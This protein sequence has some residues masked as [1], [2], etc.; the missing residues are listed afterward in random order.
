MRKNTQREELRSSEQWKQGNTR[1]RS[2]R[3]PA[4]EQVFLC[5][6]ILSSFPVDVPL[7]LQFRLAFSQY[8]WHCSVISP[9]DINNLFLIEPFILAWKNAF[10]LTLEVKRLV[11]IFG[12]T[13]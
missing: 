8:D 11:E 3:E 6:A 2:P 13:S 1:S 5:L 12:F 7:N 10:P 4:F 9:L